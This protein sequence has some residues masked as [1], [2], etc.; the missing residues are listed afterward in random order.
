MGAVTIAVFSCLNA[1]SSLSVQTSGLH[2]SALPF[3]VRSVNG[4]AISLNLLINFLKKLASPKKDLTSLTDVGV[5]QS[6]MAF[7]FDS[8]GFTP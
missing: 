4:A 1:D 7:T 2:T 6:A 8:E 5:G 3:L